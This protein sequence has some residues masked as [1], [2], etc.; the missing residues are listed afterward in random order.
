MYEY[1][2]YIYKCVLC[3]TISEIYNF[4]LSLKQSKCE[5]IHVKRNVC[6]FVS[7]FRK[8]AMAE[9]V[10]NWKIKQTHKYEYAC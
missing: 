1:N 7:L 6:I 3:N 2:I 5:H 8:D 9:G 10:G 4:V